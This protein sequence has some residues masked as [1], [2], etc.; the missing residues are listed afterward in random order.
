MLLDGENP[1][2]YRALILAAVL[3]LLVSATGCPPRE[4]IKPD[5]RSQVQAI[6]QDLLKKYGP[7]DPAN[8]DASTWTYSYH[9]MIHAAWVWM[10]K[11]SV[12]RD[13]EKRLKEGAEQFS[14]LK[15]F[16]ADQ[17]T[18]GVTES[19]RD[20]FLASISDTAVRDATA[21]LIDDGISPLNAYARAFMS[22]VLG[23]WPEAPG[24]ILILLGK[25][26]ADRPEI[27][28]FPVGSAPV[29][30]DTEWRDWLHMAVAAAG[31]PGVQEVI[32]WDD[33]IEDLQDLVPDQPFW[34]GRLTHA[35]TLRSIQLG[36]GEAYDP[37]MEA[38]SGY[39]AGGNVSGLHSWMYWDIAWRAFAG[40]GM[41]P[42][43]SEEMDG[44]DEFI[45][46]GFTQ[47]P[48]GEGEEA[49]VIA[50]ALGR[51]PSERFAVQLADALA[52]DMTC[53]RKQLGYTALAAMLNTPLSTWL[54]DKEST[55][56]VR[57]AT[58]GAIGSG[59][60]ECATLDLLSLYRAALNVFVFSAGDKLEPE[61]TDE[62]MVVINGAFMTLAPQ[63]T[64][65]DE[66]ASALDLLLWGVMQ[67]DFMVVHAE[68]R[69]YYQTLVDLHDDWERT[70]TFEN[71]ETTE[72]D[73]V[74][75]LRLFR[76]ELGDPRQLQ[77]W[78]G[79]LD[80]QGNG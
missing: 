76:N 4:E 18:S 70:T 59:K 79:P 58:V 16:A 54:V 31:K 48:M 10:G 63:L 30:E 23:K 75:L 2:M 64:T 55:G 11:Q 40:G 61:L 72:E 68:F 62:E 19:D 74:R 46:A 7:Y 44:I 26:Y 80:E 20:Q 21:V 57:A 77:K 24:M 3:I 35:Y 73:F 50:D 33:R 15:A 34:D 45:M 8:P 39:R 47:G 49:W 37:I 56:R 71:S 53:E 22:D 9:P 12:D 42:Y 66:R 27:C 60:I 29:D 32:D 78:F 36:R 67:P 13:F 69:R 38:L 41:F 25:A 1:M 52:G 65:A 14:V 51:A 17:A 5:F 28:E 43:K 6:Y